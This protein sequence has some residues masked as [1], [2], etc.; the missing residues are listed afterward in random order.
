MKLMNLKKSSYKGLIATATALTL[1]LSAATIVAQDAPTTTPTT[2]PSVLTSPAG[3][4]INM[5]VNKSRVLTTRTPYSRVSVSQAE[6]ADVNLVGPSSVLLTA[7]KP[8]LTQII[9]WDENGHSDMIDVQVSPDLAVLQEQLRTLFPGIDIEALGA[10]PDVALKGRVPNL[11]TAERAVLL[12]TPYGTKVLNFLEVAGGQQVMLKVKFMEVSRGALKNLGFNLT[13]LYSNSEWSVGV[14]L[15]P[16]AVGAPAGNLTGAGAFGNFTFDAMIDALERNSL[17]RVLAQSNL[18]AVSGQEATFLAGGEFPI[19]VPQAG[20]GGATTITVEYKE[21]GVRL[22]FVP[23]I[24]G[25]GRIRLKVAPEVSDL[26]YSNGVTISGFTIPGV[27]KRS[28]NTTVEMQEGQT[29]AL[30]G[31][32]NE[33]VSALRSQTPGLGSLPVIGTLFR[34]VRYERSETE[35]LVLVTPVYVEGISPAQVKSGPGE[36]WRDPNDVELYFNAQMGKDVGDPSKA[37]TT[38]PANLAAPRYRGAYGYRDAT[39]AT[40]SATKATEAATKAS[41]PAATAVEPLAEVV[42]PVAS[43]PEHAANER[44]PSSAGIEERVTDC[45]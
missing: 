13:S 10:G 24:L 32:L 25:D 14:N 16:A 29:L 41:E 44:S 21:F 20:S 15:T 36:K 34:S 37:A 45:I 4:A 26:D 28:L 1:T 19:P 7:K 8:G 39:K 43:T 6:V 18:V 30:G 27:T 5:T 35:L 3:G 2:R 33:R 31:L 38:R 11:Q 12:A 9:I 42:E 17:S 23:V 40:D 22:K